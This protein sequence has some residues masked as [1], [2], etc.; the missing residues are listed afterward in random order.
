ML[1]RPPPSPV[2]RFN[3]I[4]IETAVLHLALIII[5]TSFIDLLTESEEE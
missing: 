2:S 5:I 1:Y 4:Q 3:R